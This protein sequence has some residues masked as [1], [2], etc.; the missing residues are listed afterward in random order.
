MASD[1]VE[2]S[3]NTQP[4]NISVIEP[5]GQALEHVNRLLFQPFDLK[6]WFVIGFCAWLA[7]L[8]E[9]GGGG[10]GGN[11]DRHNR[12]SLGSQFEQARD[13]LMSNLAWIVPLAIAVF[14]FIL[15][16]WVLLTWLNSRG[17][18]MFLHCVARNTAEVVRPWKTYASEGNSLWLFRL[19]L[20]G[21]GFIVMMPLVAALVAGVLMMV[22][23]GKAG[24]LGIVVFLCALLL[25]LGFALALFLVKKLT[26]DFVVPIMYLRRR[27]CLE[28]WGEFRRLL[29][30]NLLH[31]VLYLLFQIVLGM[32]IVMLVLAIVLATCCC[33]GCLLCLPY[34]GTVLLLPVL[35][36]ERSY[37]L[38]Y[39]AQFGT[40]LDVFCPPVEDIKDSIEEGRP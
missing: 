25:L 32:V 13:Y 15:A 33:A 30:G 37:S 16:L 22:N 36:F 23:R 34:L 31:F 7:Y 1:L 35:A 24:A 26:S 11:F 40:E 28:C 3:M 2:A 39:L 6:K 8:G 4:A 12:D 27:K 18:F 20:G 19:I 9:G 17:R 21:V 38:F 29:S 14:L 10:S 5:V